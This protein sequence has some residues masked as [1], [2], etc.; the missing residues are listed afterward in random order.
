MKY[1]GIVCV[2][3]FL[4][5]QS[6]QS[7]SNF[8]SKVNKVES[9]LTTVE[10]GKL[11]LRQDLKL[12]SDGLLVYTVHQEN[13]KG[14]GTE[15]IYR[16]SFSD[17]DLN[18]VRSITN[19]DLIQVQLLVA[20]KQNLIQVTS[21]NG[22][23]IAYNKSLFL[24]A[25]NS[26]NANDIVEAIKALIPEAKKLEKNR[27]AL[28]TYQD[29]LKWLLEN[30]Q[31]VELPN[32]QI[33]QHL[34]INSTFNTS[35]I[36]N[37]SIHV[38]SKSVSNVYTFNLATLNPNAITYKISG[39]ELIISAATRRNVKCIKYITDGKQKNYVD[40]IK[41]YAN[42][43]TNGKD[44]FKVLKATIPLAKERFKV[45]RPE[46]LSISQSIG[47][48]NK[49]M[50]N[51]TTIETRLTQSLSINDNVTTFKLTELDPDKS[52]DYEYNFN[53]AD[54]NGNNIDYSGIKDRLFVTLPT[55]K[56][57]KFIRNSKNS[58]SQNYTNK[59][60]FFFNS[61][62]D[63]VIGTEALQNLVKLFE[64][65]ISTQSY[66]YTSVRAAIAD[67]K[68][69]LSK[70]EIGEDVYDVFVELLDPNTNTL[71][72][73]TVFSNL[74]KS[75]ETI[76]EFSLSDI[77]TKNIAIVVS[78][79]RVRVELNTKHLEKIIKTYVDGEIKPYRYKVEIETKDIE[80]ARRIAN[81][82]SV[83]L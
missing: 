17:I 7:Q 70:V 31:D 6:V 50:E 10:T 57:V 8:E 79:K 9:L 55:K 38:K 5:N 66:T 2:L 21:N 63:A 27:L 22:D 71:K 19:K 25:K 78:G 56:A 26:N 80:S 44:I 32:K 18:T 67:I 39:N 60:I 33:I 69:K 45:S 59:T 49:A 82:W 48:L 36:F 34:E 68:D 47:F 74:K 11:T 65:K 20:S 30:I 35:I 4:C 76:L 58:E 77:N 13:T 61:I 54:V 81:I 14:K 15:V 3:F 12:A 37:Q 41:I 42:S 1:C 64:G 46:V 24:Y 23:K 62:E 72:L 83:Y 51:V 52:V 75:K 28:K 73:T 43:I 40:D 53:F 29:H 16:F